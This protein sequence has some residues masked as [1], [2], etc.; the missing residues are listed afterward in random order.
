MKPLYVIALIITG[1]LSLA[2]QEKILTEA[3][4]TA[5]VTQ[6]EKDL[7]NGKHGPIRQLM[8]NE[9]KTQGQPETEYRVKS[10]GFIVPGLATH[11]V[12]DR[13]F[14][15]KPTKTE[16]LT[17]DNRSFSRDPDGNWKE[18]TVQPRT[19]SNTVKD[20]AA[21][22]QILDRQATFKYKGLELYNGRMVH[23]YTKSERQ[24]TLNTATG[25]TTGSELTATVR[26]AEGGS[27][28]RFESKSNNLFSGKNGHVKILIEVQA[29]PTIKITAPDAAK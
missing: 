22:S 21:G 16:S 7:Y 14:G 9:V 25:A 3:E 26:I 1:G 20:P 8:E 4:Y 23:V 13:S 15:G 2:A 27:Y 24:K 10:V 6:A 17:V 19:G 12:Q 11:W 29:D 18:L 5:I 28:Y